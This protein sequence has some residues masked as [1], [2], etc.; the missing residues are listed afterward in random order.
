MTMGRPARPAESAP[1][2]EPASPPGRTPPGREPAPGPLTLTGPDELRTSAGRMVGPTDPLVIG[3]DRVDG[4]EAATGGPRPGSAAGAPGAPGRLGPAAER[5]VPGL[6]LLSL[7]NFVLPKL[8]DVRG[9]AV[10]VNYGTGAVRFP[11]ALP[12]GGAVRGGLVILDVADVPGGL[13]ATYRVTLTAET[14]GQPVC[15]ADVLARYLV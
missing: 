8:V 2:A 1:L 12:A 14:T 7:V 4:F 3:V 9:F 11:S 6:L 10:G 13:Q 5:P 15:V